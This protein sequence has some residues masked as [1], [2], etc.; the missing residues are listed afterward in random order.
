MGWLDRLFGGRFTQPPPDEPVLS[1]A[2][3]MRELHPFRAELKTFTRALLARL[4]DKQRTRLLRRV[5][6]CHDQGEEPCSALVEGLTDADKGQS[7][8]QPVL[9]VVDG[10]GFDVF[11]WLAPTL[12]SASG[13]DAQYH[14]QHDSALT[15]PQVLAGFDQWLSGFGRRY[16]H[17]DEGSEEYVGCIVESASVERMLALAAEAGIPARLEAF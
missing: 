3:I 17:L 8:D 2:A 1:D 10:R 7:V 4:D 11:E 15:M 12:V 5:M 6:R 13:I 9:L 14:Y 16:V